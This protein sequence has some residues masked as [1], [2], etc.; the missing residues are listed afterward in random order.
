MPIASA[1][2]QEVMN[3]APAPPA[4]GE[5]PLVEQHGLAQAAKGG[6]GIGP[7]RRG[8]GLASR[9]RPMN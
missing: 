4:P 2:S 5:L 6:V 8:I 7:D 1:R 3:A 9:G